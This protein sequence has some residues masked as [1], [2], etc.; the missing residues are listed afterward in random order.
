M[1]ET[2]MPPAEMVKLVKR[3]L[4]KEYLDPE[5]MVMIS[6]ALRTSPVLAL[7][8]RMATSLLERAIPR[9][10]KQEATANDRLIRA[11]RELA[12]QT[13]TGPAHEARTM[14]LMSE[15][16]W[17]KAENRRRQISRTTTQARMLLR[18]RSILK[19]AGAI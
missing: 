1:T 3:A 5:E 7:K 11:A 9:V 16:E 18:I 4:G 8:I 2:K 14:F 10:A 12:K 13:I 15:V 17:M 6:K 19:S